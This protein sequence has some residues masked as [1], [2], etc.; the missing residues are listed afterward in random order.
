MTSYYVLTKPES[1]STKYIEE[2]EAC[3]N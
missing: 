1:S 2:T 3:K